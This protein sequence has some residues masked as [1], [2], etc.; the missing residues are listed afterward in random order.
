LLTRWRTQ[1]KQLD[2]ARHLDLPTLN[3]HIPL[4]LEELAAAFRLSTNETVADSHSGTPPA[5]GL[6]RLVDGFE[7]EE[8]VAEYNILRGCIHDLAT[9]HNINLQGRPFNILNLVLD[10][11]IGA[12]VQTFAERRA[13]DIQEKREE[14]L[15]FVAH[16]L[17]TPLNAISLATR[18]LELSMTDQDK[19][20]QTKTMLHTLH[21]NVQHL[22]ALV[23]KILD[24]SAHLETELGVK[25][26]RRM[27]DLW[28]LVE[29][30]I[31]GLHPI[32]GT[33][34]T[35]LINR[36]PEDMMVFADA[37]LLVRIFQNLI[38]NAILYTPHGEVVISALMLD[39]EHA[40]ECCVAD[41]G[42]GIPAERI[43][44]IF[45]KF[46][47]DPD[48]IDSLGL[49]LAIVKTFVDAH[50]GTLSVQSKQRN[51]SEFKFVLPAK[52]R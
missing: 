14:Y 5:H 25:L 51:G 35:R 44:K 1:L 28:P 11:A 3:D 8:V 7:I 9:E 48:N 43:D 37:S 31:H 29:N 27:L 41:N 33:D 23:D 40:V 32:A 18:V 46:E 19:A 50:G 6:Q 36:V 16:D 42:R 49:G 22:S 17:R 26:E 4:L 47:A 10:G 13:Q 2:S 12:A 20:A 52:N 21:R 38:A 39:D 30:L 15:S 34:S 24:E 45:G